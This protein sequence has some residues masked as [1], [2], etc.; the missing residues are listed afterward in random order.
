[1]TELVSVD[2]LV[3]TV[4]LQHGSANVVL[5]T[6]RTTARTSLPRVFS[7][8]QL[9]DGPHRRDPEPAHH[10]LTNRVR[11]AVGE[12]ALLILIALSLSACEDSAQVK[13]QA[14]TERAARVKERALLGPL[15]GCLNYVGDY[16]RHKCSCVGNECDAIHYGEWD[17]RITVTKLRCTA[18]GCLAR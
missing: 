11:R 9:A 4:P 2:R 17:G 18:E 13:R 14:A 12:S 1:M 16:G 10:R 5:N 7:A 6:C 3:R 15:G 8:E